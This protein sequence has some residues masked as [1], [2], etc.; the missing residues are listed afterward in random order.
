MKFPV[1]KTAFNSEQ[2]AVITVTLL[3]GEPFLLTKRRIS[4]YPIVELT[5][6]F[7]IYIYILFITLCKWKLY[8]VKLFRLKFTSQGCMSAEVKCIF[9]GFAKEMQEKAM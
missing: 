6:V 8:S 3:L 1:V 9:K 7:F 4:C 5:E 2:R